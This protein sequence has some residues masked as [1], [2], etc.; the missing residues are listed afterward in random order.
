MKDGDNTKSKLNSLNADTKECKK[1]KDD[2]KGR[3]GELHKNHRKRLDEKISKYGFESLPD[4]EKLESI[5]YVVIPRGDTNEIA[6]NLLNEFGTIGGVLNAGFERLQKVN[7]IGYR[8][9]RFLSELNSIAGEVLRYSKC[10][11][12]LL[13]TNEKIIEY[14][15]TYYIGRLTECS[16]MFTLD[17]T[18]HLTGVIKLSEGT[19][20][21]TH[22]YPQKVAEYAI[23]HK[24]DSVIIAHNHPAGTLEPSEQDVQVA[25][26]VEMA[27]MGV[28]VNYYDNLIITP[29]NYYS[30]KENGRLL[31]LNWVCE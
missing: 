14:I 3:N 6:H 27:L 23:M 28:G 1:I 4:H 20:N 17:R 30:F 11:A 9:A 15:S 12:Y 2:K 5:L 26:A 18:M 25:K 21:Q 24:A 10:G 7:G 22:V 13:D 19:V 8:T 31:K 16:Y 29:D